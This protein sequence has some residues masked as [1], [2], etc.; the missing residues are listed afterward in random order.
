LYANSLSLY[1]FNTVTVISKKLT[2]LHEYLNKNNNTDTKFVE[3]KLRQVYRLIMT[4]TT[5]LGNGVKATKSGIGSCW[6]ETAHKL[7]LMETQLKTFY[8]ECIWLLNQHYNAA[9]QVMNNYVIYARAF[10]NTYKNKDNLEAEFLDQTEILCKTAKRTLNL[11][12]AKDFFNEVNTL[13]KAES[14]N[15]DKQLMVVLDEA[16]AMQ[17]GKK[18]GVKGLTFLNV[19]KTLIEEDAETSLIEYIDK[20]KEL[21]KEEWKDE[22]TMKATT[23]TYFIYKRWHIKKVTLNC[24]KKYG[25]NKDYFN[26]IRALA[27][28]TLDQIMESIIDLYD[29]LIGSPFNEDGT[30]ELDTKGNLKEVKDKVLEGLEFYTK[31]LKDTIFNP[32]VYKVPLEFARSNLLRLRG[33]CGVLIKK[34]RDGMIIICDKSARTFIVVIETLRNPEKIME[35]LKNKCKNVKVVLTGCVLVLD[36]DTDGWVSINDLW[37]SMKRLYGALRKMNYLGKPKGSYIKAISSMKLIKSELLEDTTC[38]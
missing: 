23:A 15:G 19:Y 30:V 11:I 9:L 20:C 35:Y 28:Y 8:Q 16:V 26:R 10:Y 22:Y 7:S 18:C 3:K 14:P 25:Q 24:L 34:F 4:I 29:S 27:R 36:F 33:V 17:L 5:S 37:N 1:F 13:W 21:F 31:E 12:E 2:E 38:G 32:R 6:S